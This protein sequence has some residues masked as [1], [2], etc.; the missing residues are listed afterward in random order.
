MEKLNIIKYL[1]PIII[2]TVIISSCAQSYTP[3][4]KISCVI[5]FPHDNAEYEVKIQAGEYE[6][7]IK[8]KLKIYNITMFAV[9]GGHTSIF[10]LKF[11]DRNGKNS[12]RLIIYKNKTEYLKYSYEE[13]LGFNSILSDSILIY[14]IKIN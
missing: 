9:Q 8:N 11:N 7:L 12:P 2:S 10:G 13:I 5:D 1:L 3:E 14:K 4:L 6:T